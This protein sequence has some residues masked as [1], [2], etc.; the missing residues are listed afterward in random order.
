VDKN[1]HIYSEFGV[2]YEHV[3]GEHHNVSGLILY[4]QSKYYDPNLAYHIPNG[5]QGLVGRVTYNYHNRYLAEFNIGYNGTENF[6]E[7]K[8]FGIFPAYSLGWIASEESFFPENKYLTFLKIRGSYGSVGNSKIGGARFLYLPTAYTYSDGVYLYGEALGGTYADY[9][10]SKEGKLG[11]PD[12]TWEKANKLNVGADFRLW[13]DKIG[14]TVD[15]FEEKRNNILWNRETVPTIIGVNMP[16]YNLGEMENKGFEGEI[17]FHDRVG[18]V[19]YFVKGNYT[20]AHN[21]I[22]FQD[23]V[24]RLY[25][26]Q[27][28]T[29]QRFGQFFGYVANGLFN[30]WEEVNDPNRPIYSWA[31]NKIQPGDIRYKDINGDGF[32]NDLDQVPIGFSDFPEVVFGVSFGAEWKGFDFSVLFQ[33]ASNVSAFPSRRTFRGF[34]ENTGATRDLLKSWSQE[35]YENGETIVYPRLAIDQGGQNYAVSTYWLEDASYLRL[36][37]A[38]IGYTFRGNLLKQIG[39]GSLRLYLNGNNLLTWCR[40]LPGQDPEYKSYDESYPVTR[41]INFGL[42]VNF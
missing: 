30:T 17:S 38:E 31:N 25:D 24:P 42:N 27:Y 21:K 19:N 8:R 10:G 18:A 4:N 7:G 34:Y 20:F 39:V 35:R 14:I 28:R 5:E 29:G 11:N 12:L 36:K 40:L 6:A 33:G 3:F 22:L 15:Y 13:D 16:A 2:A 26:Y 9:Q 37:N 1:T 32:I 41:V 23:E